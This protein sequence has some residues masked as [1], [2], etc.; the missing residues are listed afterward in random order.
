MS[1]NESK[2]RDVTAGYE[3]TQLEIQRAARAG[4]ALNP[5][6]AIACREIIE[7][8]I[9]SILLVGDASL[10]IP[11]LLDATNGI[12]TAAVPNGA[13]GFPQ[14]S[15]KTSAEILLDVEQILTAAF[16]AS[17]GS[18]STF[19]LAVPPTEWGQ[20]ATTRLDNTQQTTLMA[21][22]MDRLPMLSD[23]VWLPE[24]ATSGAGGT[25]EMILAPS[26]PGASAAFHAVIPEEYTEAPPFVRHWATEI[27][28]AARCGGTI[29][30]KP[31]QLLRRSAIA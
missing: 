15:T 11:G 8:E 14:W 23:V 5:E 6:K 19:V 3:W 1:E 9:N 17:Q 31:F 21:Y 2:I 20:L 18:V 27:A 13:G 12:A 4:V 10:A 24:L 28:A 22:M 29:V 16:S 25:G 7:T 30:R 26:G